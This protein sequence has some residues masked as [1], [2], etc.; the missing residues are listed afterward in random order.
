MNYYPSQEVGTI[1]SEGFY[2]YQVARPMLC[3]VQGRRNILWPE[4]KFYE[5]TINTEIT[6]LVETGP[7]PNYQWSEFCRQSIHLAEDYDVQGIITLGSMFADCPHTRDLPIDVL[8]ND[9][10]ESN[11][12]DHSGPVGIPTVLDALASQAG[13]QTEAIWVSV[14]QYLGSD[15]CALGSLQ[16]LRCL[17]KKLGIALNEGDLPVKAE[18]W[19]AQASVL[20][21]CN[22]ELAE[23]V[24]RLEVE[25]DTKATERLQQNG[26]VPAAEELVREA[27]AFLKSMG[28]HDTASS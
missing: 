24:H 13:F 26:D 28:G 22:D 4:T 12:E 23:Y 18:H 17:S 16:L 2:D 7:E 25:S 21:R 20:L 1:A 5:V 14:P 8:S 6:L 3:H 27:E 10:A 15:E 9:E 11:P 19:K